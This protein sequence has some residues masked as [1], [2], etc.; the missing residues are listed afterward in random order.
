MFNKKFMILAIFL[1][2]LLAVSAVSAQD[3]ATG[4]I[5]SI[6]E[7][8]I[9]TDVGQIA[10]ASDDGE[11]ADNEISNDEEV[12]DT[13]LAQ[14]EEGS[15]ALEL[16][17]GDFNL[18][19]LTTEVDINNQ[20]TSIFYFD[21]PDGFN[22]N[23]WVEVDIGYWGVIIKKE[24]PYQVY[25]AIT[26]G[27]LHILYDSGYYNYTVFYYDNDNDIRMDL[28]YSALNVTGQ[29][30]GSGLGSSHKK[31][32]SPD[33]YVAIVCDPIEA[34]IN[35]TVTIYVEDSLV[36]SKEFASGANGS[37]VIYAKE[38]I[39]NFNG[40]YTVRFVYKKANGTQ[41]SRS[42]NVS[43][44]KI[45]NNQRKF[46]FTLVNDEVDIKDEGATIFS[47][48]WPEDAGQW[49]Q[50]SIESDTCYPKNFFKADAPG[51]SVNVTLEDF[52]IWWPGNYDF[53]VYYVNDTDGSKLQIANATLK[54]TKIY[55]A[56]D[57]IELYGYEIYDSNDHVAVICDPTD[58]GLNGTVTIY[59][60]GN[61]VFSKK[62]AAGTDEGQ[63]ILAKQLTGNFD[64]T[65][66]IKVVYKKANGTEYVRE[67]SVPFKKIYN[68]PLSTSISASGMTV[69][70]GANKYLVATLKGSDGKAISGASVIINIYGV[71]YTLKT[72]KYGKIKQSLAS[73]PPK[74]HTIKFT[75]K[76]T[77]KY[78]ASTKSVKVTVKKATPK[79]MAA[80]K[81]FK[82]ADKI[83]KYVVTLKDNNNKVMKSTLVYIKVNGITYSA[84]TNAKGQATFKLTKLKKVGSF[85]AA[86]TFKGN[87][88]YN[89]ISKAVKITVKK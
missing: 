78:L 21:W 80:A 18:T 68:N 70:Y 52:Y 89:K 67:E 82:L 26:L 76:K 46:N 37:Q 40:E 50:I 10:D 48:D 72:D 7:K 25:K 58:S 49:D 9:D 34:G 65:Y 79:F 81:A 4:D 8:S 20:D 5:A 77:G 30:N 28:A 14:T 42:E 71:S 19:I 62:Y 12:N 3:N 56:Y 16:E 55:D 32:S 53:T 59:A 41:Y 13:E 83:K 44:V 24:D 87:A 43:F 73:L 11:L 23:V 29:Y 57:F 15:D 6:G 74:V 54:V 75:F 61:K 51:A 39:G 60:N 1:V 33:D 38:L 86:I 31:I 22:Q 45:Y 88:Y 64:G 84:K 69:V 63:L 27:D 36:Y 47:F 2:S 66:T 35:G 17:P 85:S